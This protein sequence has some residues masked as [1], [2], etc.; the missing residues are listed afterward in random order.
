MLDIGFQ[1]LSRL[2]A[3]GKPLKVVVLDTQVYSNTGG[4]ACTSGFH[5]QV[6]DMAAWGGAQHGKSEQRKEMGLLAIAHRGAFVVQSSAATPTHL[7]GGVLRGLAS[8]RPAVFNLYTPCQAEHGIADSGSAAAARLALEGRAFPCFVYDPDGGASMAE[9]LDLAANPAG[10]AAWPRHKLEICGD[11]GEVKGVD[12]PFTTADWAVTEPRFHRHFE[13]LVEV[14]EEARPLADYLELSR[15]GRASNVPYIIVRGRDGRAVRLAVSAEMV[16]LCE[17]RQQLWDLLR[18]LAGKRVQDVVR[19][20]IVAP[21]VRRHEAELRVLEERHQAE[22]AALRA[23][24]AE[25]VD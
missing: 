7:L 17:D 21:L 24:G 11:D 4:Q 19:D 3:S 14:G 22:L 23:R 6:S 15:A 5:G 1:N 10:N 20:A 2:L 16:S 25:L 18:E 12:L 9:R 8:H 13:P